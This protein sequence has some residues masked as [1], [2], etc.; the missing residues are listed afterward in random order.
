MQQFAAQ[1]HIDVVNGAL[2]SQP[3]VPWLCGSETKLACACPLIR[4]VDGRAKAQIGQVRLDKS[5]GVLWD[6]V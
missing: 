3:R 4:I 6:L 1:Q 2:Y 5:Q